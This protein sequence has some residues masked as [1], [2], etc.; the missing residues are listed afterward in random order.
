[1]RA[2]DHAGCAAPE[3]YHDNASWHWRIHCRRF[4]RAALLAANTWLGVSSGWIH[5]VG[6]LRV[7]PALGLGQVGRRDGSLRTR[8]FTSDTEVAALVSAFENATIPASEFTHAAHIAVAL[9]YLDAFSP[10]QALERMREKIR[11]F[12]AHHGVTNLYHETLTTFWMRLLE[13]VAGTCDV[14]PSRR[15]VSVKADLPIWRRI[16]LIVEDWTKRR[17]IEAHYSTE[18]IK[19]QAAR[20]NWIPPDRLPLPF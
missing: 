14:D 10:E 18:L 6:N 17:P 7:I 13:H 1:V 20:E 2:R 3:L 9:S 8:D 5:H 12:A 4:D 19:S 15:S 11:A 16:N